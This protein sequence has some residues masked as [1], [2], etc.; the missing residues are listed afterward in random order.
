MYDRVCV[1]VELGFIQCIVRFLCEEDMYVPLVYIR[2]FG[3]IQIVRMCEI[4]V[5]VCVCVIHIV[6]VSVIDIV[7]V[8]F[9][10]LLMVYESW[11]EW[12]DS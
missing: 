11:Y 10:L 3:V 7:I 2:C 8:R 9:R 4:F 6:V 12:G 1:L 5:C